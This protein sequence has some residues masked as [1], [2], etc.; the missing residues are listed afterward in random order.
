LPNRLPVFR[1][2]FNSFRDEFSGQ[3]KRPVIFDIL[4][5]DQETSLLP[6]DLRLVLHVN[7]K[8]MTLHYDKNITRIQ[9]KGGF[10]EQH[11][12]D[13]AE[14]ISFAAATGGFMRLYAGLSSKTGSSF[15][16]NLQSTG[17][18]LTA[19]QGRRETIA[20][21]KFLDLLA[22]FHNNGSIYDVNGNI[23][24]QGYMKLTF[25]GGVYIGWFDGDFTVTES[26]LKPYQF[27][28]SANFNIDREELVLRSTLLNTDTELFQ[29]GT[30][31]PQFEP[32]QTHI[33]GSDTPLDGFLNL[34][35]EERQ[36]NV[37]QGVTS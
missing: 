3:G 21:D 7:P 29:P 24:I 15:G 2:A 19:V 14:R 35:E 9:T 17:P 34:F 26:A 20:Y 30:S 1:S 6:E 16:G 28:L 32:G 8:S 4:S 37:F 33:P 11:W 5:S 22:L 18:T 25:D 13:A 12:G 23:V 36:G 10:V 27:E 31:T